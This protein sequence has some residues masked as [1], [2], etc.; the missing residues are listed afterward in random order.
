MTYATDLMLLL[1]DPTKG[2]PVADS[3]R[4]PLVLG[5]AVLLELAATDSIRISG[6][7]EAVRKD[8]VVPTAIKHDDPILSDGLSTLRGHRPMHPQ[9]AVST[10]SKKLQSKVIAQ[11]KRKRQIA[12]E[13]D[14]VLGIFP[15]TKWYPRDRS[16]R[17]EIREELE[18]VLTQ[19]AEPDP[20]SSALISLLS[21]VD[22][23]PKVFPD[24]D[25]KAIRKR[26]KE[27]AAGD[28]AA[29]AVKDAVASVE[30]A[31]IAGVVG[32]SA[33]AASGS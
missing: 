9:S 4:L 3:T 21:A 20:R 6:P 12:E 5:G 17:E 29:K 24:A 22:V 8:R 11:L 30:A 13:R 32:A 26:A 1:L 15:L 10:L 23:V 16:R 7:G 27:I 31:I 19:G 2:R 25:K 18:K 33:A 28:W 14:R